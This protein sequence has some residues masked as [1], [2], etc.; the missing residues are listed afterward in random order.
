VRA[1]ALECGR[2]ASVL[3]VLEAGPDHPVDLRA[4]EGR[5]L[6]GL[7]LRVAP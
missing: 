6:T 1:A 5:Y 2:A 7:L 3:R 4:P